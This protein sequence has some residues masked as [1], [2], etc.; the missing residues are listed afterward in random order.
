MV[1]VEQP[2]T[3][4]DACFQHTHF[5][6][7]SGCGKRETHMNLSMV[8]YKGSTCYWNYLENYRP[9]AGGLSA[10]NAIGTQLRG[11]LIC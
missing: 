10:V 9:C 6:P 2:L 1:V 3:P 11:D 4:I 5:I 8:T 7:I